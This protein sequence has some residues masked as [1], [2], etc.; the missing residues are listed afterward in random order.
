ASGAP[1]L[2]EAV[3]GSR[4]QAYHLKSGKLLGELGAKPEKKEALDLSETFF[5]GPPLPIH[6]RLY[7]LTERKEELK[8]L[9]LESKS[10]GPKNWAEVLWSQSLATTNTPILK[11]P[12]RRVH[13]AHLA[14]GEGILVCP[15]NS[16]A[17]LGVDMLTH[18]LV[19]AYAYL[20]KRPANPNDPNMQ[21]GL[22]G[23]FR[24]V[25]VPI[26]PN[27]LPVNQQIKPSTNDW[28]V[29]SPVITD[30]KVVFTAYDAGAVHCLNLRDGSEVWKKDKQEEGVYL[31]GV[32]N[33]KV[34]IVG[35]KKCRALDLANGN[36]VWEKVT[37]PPSGMGVISENVFYLPV[38]A[39][40]GKTSEPEVCQIDIDNGN[41]LAH[42]KS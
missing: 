31:A 6:G 38:K 12:A 16:G 19:W 14:Y 23:P 40:V 29:S 30:G 28:K 21:P 2:Q 39:G 22:G 17:V 26:G 25:P 18:S 9:C 37:G 33:G 8:L 41:I 20:P 32:Q 35:K 5:L 3:E 13:A 11:D 7:V 27:G 1:A 42:T 15:P 34:I 36:Q 10:E 24:P 4:L